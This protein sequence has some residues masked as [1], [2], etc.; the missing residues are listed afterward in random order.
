MKKVIATIMAAGLVAQVA[1]AT[2]ASVDYVS[3]YVFR[4]ATSSSDA[5]LQPS[6]EGEV[7][8][9]TVGTWASYNIDSTVVEEVDLY[10]AYPLPSLIEGVDLGLVATEYTYQGKLEDGGPIEAQTELGLTASTTAYG[11]GVDGG[12]YR[13]VDAD[14]NLYAEISV[15]GGYDLTADIA[16]SYGVTAGYIDEDGGE[17]GVSYYAYSFGAER[18]ISEDLTLGLTYVLLEDGDTDSNKV[19]AED[20]VFIVSV[21]GDF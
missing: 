6:V 13:E 3:A 7:M 17:S 9:A 12:V 8:G 11:F 4:G 21:G 16:A 18:A 2:S 19:G 10:I 15:S 1:S 5:A 14:N 20:S